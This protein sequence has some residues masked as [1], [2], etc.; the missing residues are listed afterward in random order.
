LR[1]PSAQEV[2]AKGACTKCGADVVAGVD[3]CGKCKKDALGWK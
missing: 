3:T 2:E 1:L